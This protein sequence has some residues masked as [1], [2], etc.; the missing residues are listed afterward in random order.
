MVARA[1]TSR[2]VGIGEA[3]HGTHDFYWWRAAPSKRLIEE[4][5]DSLTWLRDRN[6]SVRPEERV[7]FYGLDVYSLWDS[8]AEIIRW[9]Q[10]Y[11]P[12]S[13]SR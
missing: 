8:L 9:L 6:M 1:S 2:L 13:V 11:S 5:A 12:E 10:N 7:G 3:S 4:V